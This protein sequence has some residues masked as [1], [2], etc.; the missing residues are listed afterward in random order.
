[1][2]DI[3]YTKWIRYPVA[4]LRFSMDTERG[5]PTRFLVQLERLVE[6]EWLEVVRFDHDN[7][8]EQSHDIREEGLHMDIYRDG[9]KYLVRDDFPPMGLNIAPAYAQAYIESEA[10]RLLRRFD[11]WHNLTT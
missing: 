5:S 2:A 11:Q 10:D 9:E 1:M 7:E 6:D 3:E 8:G 4:Q